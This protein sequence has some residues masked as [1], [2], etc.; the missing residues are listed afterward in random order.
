MSKTN[1]V[2]VSDAMVFRQVIAGSGPGG[3]GARFASNSAKD[4][5]AKA[6]DPWCSY[7]VL[8]VYSFL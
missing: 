3:S 4:S 7:K 8:I 5:H 2:K 1:Q 6:R